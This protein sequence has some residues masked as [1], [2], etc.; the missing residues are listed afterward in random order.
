MA[1]HAT[2]ESPTG[3]EREH[4]TQSI[5]ALIK[6]N[7]RNQPNSI[8]ANQGDRALTYEQLDKASLFLAAFFDSHGI[9]PGVT[10]PVFLSR[11]LE[12]VAAILALMRLGACFVPMDARAWSQARVDAVLQAVEPNLVVAC[13]RSELNAAGYPMI[14][15]EDVRSTYDASFSDKEVPTV[16]GELDSPGD[17]KHPLYIIFTSGTTGNPKGVVIPRGCVENYVM[18]GCERGMPFN[19][20]VGSDDKVLLLFSLAFDGKCSQET[21]KLCE[22]M[23]T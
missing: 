8:A 9:K 5:C 20:G 21:M 2:T 15:A 12:S 3:S 6:A 16:T 1:P 23:L 22:N 13:E 10:I 19:L 17:P 4:R 7:A 11:S 18:Q 14:D